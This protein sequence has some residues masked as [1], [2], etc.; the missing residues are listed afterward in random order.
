MD[1]RTE[2]REGRCTR[3]GFGGFLDADGR[4]RDCWARDI[5]R[6]DRKLRRELEAIADPRLRAECLE[7]F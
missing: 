6:A 7:A 4:C 2:V 1:G 5:M 3:C